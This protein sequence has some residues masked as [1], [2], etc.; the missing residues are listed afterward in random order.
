MKATVSTY[1]HHHACPR[2]MQHCEAQKSLCNF[3]ST[4][5]RSHAVSRYS[6]LCRNPCGMHPKPHMTLWAF[7]G[8]LNTRINWM[9][10]QPHAK[11]NESSPAPV[12]ACALA[13]FTQYTAKS[14]LSHKQSTSQSLGHAW[15][16][17][18]QHFNQMWMWLCLWPAFYFHHQHGHANCPKS[19]NTLYRPILACSNNTAQHCAH[20]WQPF[21]TTIWPVMY[22]PHTRPCACCMH[23]QV[24]SMQLSAW[25]VYVKCSLLCALELPL[26]GP[27]GHCL[28]S[29][30]PLSPEH[31][32]CV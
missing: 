22:M 26:F 1:G 28:L 4:N 16:P 20:L 13:Q 6:R 23:W 27:V 15:A 9:M 12:H 18:M 25:W 8:A 32:G 17:S 31:V 19:R 24:P 14:I 5:S 3:A 21:N 29:L 7:A 10:I 2:I 30:W 11:P